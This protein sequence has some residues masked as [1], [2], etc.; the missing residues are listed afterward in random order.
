MEYTKE[1]IGQVSLD[2][3]V[4]I[5]PGIYSAQDER[6]SI[7][8]VWLHANHHAA[9]ISEEVR[10]GETGGELL[11]EIADFAMWLFTTA[12]KLRGT[13]GAKNSRHETEPETIIRINHSYSDLLWNKYPAMCPVCYWRRSK[14]DRSKER[15]PGFERSCDCLLHD[16]EKRNQ[17]QKIQH[18]EALRAFSNDKRS[19]K[20][21]RV[22]DWQK[23]FTDIFAANIRH[24]RLEDI[25]F[26]L[27]EEMGE[28]SDAIVR[29]Y[30][31]K[32]EEFI[33]GEPRWRQIWLEEELADVTSWLFSLVEKLDLIRRTADE[34]DK[35]RYA[36]TIVPRG[37]ILL[38][39]IIWKRYGLEYLKKFYCPT[40]K[41]PEKCGCE[42]LIV[43]VDK[44]VDQL[45]ALVSNVPKV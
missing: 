39:G 6:R 18:V 1:N 24:S 5:I 4:D 41:I 21:T 28:V 33:P 9:A 29:M 8:D 34:Y 25:A 7:W 3:L 45:A 40:C 26:H 12:Y 43:P 30:T 27:L 22:D 44:T 17:S 37:P 16:V 10:K 15:V 20:R 42:I 32:N 35:W 23:M 13:I 36:E 11:K 31:Y 14:G 38:S 2:E 19:Q